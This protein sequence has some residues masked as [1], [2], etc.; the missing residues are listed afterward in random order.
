MKTTNVTVVI[1]FC[2]VTIL[3]SAQSAIAQR[4]ISKGVQQISNKSWLATE[5][6]LTVASVD[7]AP[8]AVSKRVQLSRDQQRVKVVRGNMVS[9]GYPSWIISK[10]VHRIQAVPVKTKPA[11]PF[12][13]KVI[14]NL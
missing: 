10:G 6:L 9:A 13:N 7:N 11:K 1:A 14:V 4:S 2:M 8:I 5:Q 3:V 12:M